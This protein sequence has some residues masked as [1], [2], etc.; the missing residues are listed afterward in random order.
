MSNPELIEATAT[1]AEG[2]GSA[3]EILSLPSLSAGNRPI[4]SDDFEVAGTI[5][6]AGIRPIEASHMAIYGT[7]MN[8]RP[9]MSSNLKVAE[10]LPGNRPIFYS[11][12]H[13]VEGSETLGRPV[14]ASEPGLLSA[15]R[16]MGD[17]PV[18]SNDLD[19]STAL[20]GFID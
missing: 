8:G 18:F 4:M 13:A 7:I 6:S 3:L 15:N 5:Q 19:D 12:F 11:D 10:M 9:I 20:M 1:P 17:R 16:H 2:N 14:M